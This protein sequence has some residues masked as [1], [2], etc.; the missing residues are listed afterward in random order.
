MIVYSNGY[1]FEKNRLWEH[2][3]HQPYDYMRKGLKSKIM[4]ANIAE[5][6]N[7]IT[8]RMTA[9]VESSIVYLLK[10]IDKLRYW[11]AWTLHNR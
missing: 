2:L 5:S 11:K 8:Q 10:S 4:S 3:L 1:R 9:F 7:V 6:S